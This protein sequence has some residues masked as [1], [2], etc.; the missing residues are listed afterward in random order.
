MGGE[1][2]VFVGTPRAT[3]LKY[4]EPAANARACHIGSNRRPAPMETHTHTVDTTAIC[5]RTMPLS[6]LTRSAQPQGAAGATSVMRG[7]S[8]EAQRDANARAPP[9]K[10]MYGVPEVPRTRAQVPTTPT[11][12]IT[13]S[14]NLRKSALLPW[15]SWMTEMCVVTSTTRPDAPVDAAWQ[16]TAGNGH[17]SGGHS[18]RALRGHRWGGGGLSKY[19]K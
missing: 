10:L 17:R 2:K 1:S 15:T 6:C 18:T 3:I 14:K 9:T 4:F 19:N 12:H 13:S 11:S 5:D 7:A 16:L 8:V